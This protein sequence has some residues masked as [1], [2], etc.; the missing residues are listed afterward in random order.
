MKHLIIQRI[1]QEWPSSINN[2]KRNV[3]LKRQNEYFHN[4]MTADVIL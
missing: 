2:F 1:V 4:P 3:L